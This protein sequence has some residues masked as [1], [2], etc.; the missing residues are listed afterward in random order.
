MGTKHSSKE[1]RDRAKKLAAEI[2]ATHLEVDIDEIVSGFVKSIKPIIGREPNFVKH[3]G[4][5]TEDLALQNVQAR[6]R[7]VMSYLLA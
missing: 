7:M 1:T 6:S 5:M 4:T 3:G 2:G